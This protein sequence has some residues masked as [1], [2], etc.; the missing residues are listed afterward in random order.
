[1]SRLRPCCPQCMNEGLFILGQ[2][3]IGFRK[4]L[5]PWRTAQKLIIPG[6]FL[7]LIPADSLNPVSANFLRAPPPALSKL[8]EGGCGLGIPPI[9]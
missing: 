2:F 3:Q 1:V 4:S 8:F 6:S 5:T 7:N 9:R